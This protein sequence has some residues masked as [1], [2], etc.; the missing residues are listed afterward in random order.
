MAIETTKEEIIQVERN[1]VTQA[2][3]NSFFRHRAGR[4]GASQSKAVCQAY[5]AMPSQSLIQSLCY[6]KLNGLNIKTIFMGVNMNRKQS[7]LMK[8]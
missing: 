6:P 2:K 3:G 1:T 8:R 7:A 5:P 4:I